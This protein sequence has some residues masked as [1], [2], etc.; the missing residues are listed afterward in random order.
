MGFKL[1]GGTFL[2]STFD[3]RYP[4][5]LVCHSILD[6]AVGNL[7][8]RFST[9]DKWYWAGTFGTRYELER[10][11]KNARTQP[12]AEIIYDLRGKMQSLARALLDSSY[13]FT[14]TNM[15]HTDA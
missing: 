11:I 14:V 7:P 2:A 13:Y 4:E 10:E 15:I 9:L 12:L 6:M 8:S 5:F 1:S 3:Q